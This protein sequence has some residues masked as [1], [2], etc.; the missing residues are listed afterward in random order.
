VTFFVF[1]T[2]C[3]ANQWDSHVLE[4]RLEGAGLNRAAPGQAD[5]IVVNACSLTA[6]AE[7][8]ARRFIRKAKEANPR[9]RIA[10]VGCHAQVYPLRDFGADLV[11]GQAEKFDA[12]RYLAGGGRFVGQVRDVAIE[13]AWAGG[14]RKD[15]TRFFFKIQDGCSRFCSYCI[16][17]YARGPVRSRP[18]REVAGVMEALEKHGVKE[19]VLTGIDLAAYRDP[20][21]K[22]GL[23]ELLIFLERRPTP[24]RIRLSSVDPGYIDEGFIP[25]IAA[26]CKIA[27]SVHIPVQSGSDRILA[28]MGRTYS[29]SSIRAL[30]GKLKS[31]IPD[32]G[33]GMDVMVGFPGEDEEDF[34]ATLEMV[35]DLDVSYLHVFPYS[36]REGA[37][38][39]AF[40]GKV[41]EAVKKARAK[42]LKLVD[43]R[44]RDAFMR[45]HIG[46]TARIIPEG[47]VY[48]GRLMRGFSDN[49]LPVYIPYEKRLENNLVD[50]TIREMQDGR[51]IGGPLCS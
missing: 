39:S 50:V 16:V 51:L 22:G 12:G 34:R 11:L 41:A 4:G 27:K 42:T 44:K 19:V 15:R 43:S 29:A 46:R 14:G 26:S 8:D 31:S 36:D 13:Q 18:A 38:A 23:K 6:R 10:L 21:S 40:E 33:I 32:I 30:V 17:P 48:R 3:K 25:V 35:E 45:R 2:G 24:P 47:K 7:V 49:Y 1:T 20:V 9:A 37:R 5:L 28:A